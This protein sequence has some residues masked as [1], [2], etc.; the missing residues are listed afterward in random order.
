M[1]RIPL[2]LALLAALGT[3]LAMG[4]GG[5]SPGTPVV[6]P[7]QD[8]PSSLSLRGPD[9]PSYRTIYEGFRSVVGDLPLTAEFGANAVGITEALVG[10]VDTPAAD[11]SGNHNAGVAGYARTASPRKYA[12]GL[13]GGG[14]LNA[15]N[16]GAWGVNTVTSN[17]PCL[18]PG[19][20]GA[21]GAQSGFDMEAGFGYEMDVNIVPKADGA[22]PVGYFDGIAETGASTVLPSGGANAIHIGPFGPAGLA[23]TRGFYTA[24]G[25]TTTA[26]DI[27][28]AAAGAGHGS[29]PIQLRSRNRTG[30]EVTSRI[31][32]DPDGNL[33]LTAAGGAALVATTGA[34][35]PML[36][37]S[38]AG[39]PTGVLW[40]NAGVVSICP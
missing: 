22:A 33:V 37:K 23:W 27:G 31:S 18:S 40:N 21:C 36:P 16:A 28:A 11:T 26:V 10:A 5:T 9:W 30:K 39:Q 6:A 20:A 3:V 2:I 13:F 14:M 7:G 38:C 17:A 35:K 15:N 32:T 29:Q 19:A 25:A 34:L 8:Q 24:D 12:V 1:T 4:P